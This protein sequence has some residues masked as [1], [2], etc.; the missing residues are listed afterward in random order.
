M[1]S[2]NGR[3]HVIRHVLTLQIFGIPKKL[4]FWQNRKEML[5]RLNFA[6]ELSCIKA[7]CRDHGMKSRAGDMRVVRVIRIYKWA[8]F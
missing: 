7:T 4:R 8:E 6:S 1:L 5:N 3:S 2:V